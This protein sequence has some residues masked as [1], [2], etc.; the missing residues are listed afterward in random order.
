MVY[1]SVL[2]RILY[3]YCKNKAIKLQI[4]VISSKNKPKIHIRKYDERD[5]NGGQISDVKSERLDLKL[6]FER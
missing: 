6:A 1:D 5:E 3:L 2:N 4:K